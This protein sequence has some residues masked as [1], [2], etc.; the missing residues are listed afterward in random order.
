MVMVRSEANKTKMHTQTERLTSAHLHTLRYAHKA[1]QR[2]SGLHRHT[3]CNTT[4]TL[5]N[6]QH[7]TL[8]TKE[9]TEKTMGCKQTHSRCCLGP[10]SPRSH[11]VTVSC[12]TCVCASVCIQHA[13]L[14]LFTMKRAAF[15]FNYEKKETHSREVREYANL[16]ARGNALSGTHR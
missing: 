7:M 4:H 14:T 15:Q 13:F 3:L 6:K 10:I 9:G 1:L 16:A 12:G 11:G 5:T 8:C 2:P